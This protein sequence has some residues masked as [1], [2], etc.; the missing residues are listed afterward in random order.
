MR[1]KIAGK[2]VSELLAAPVDRATRRRRSVRLYASS[3]CGYDWGVRPEGL[4]EQALQHL[5]EGYTAMKLRIGTEWAWDGVTVERFVDLMRALSKAVDGRM[6]L[7]LDGNQRL[8]E[9][10]ALTIA[11]VLDE[12]RFT[13]F[14]EPI[15]QTDIEGYARLNAVVE[16]PITGGEQFATVEQFRPYLEQRAYDIVQPDAGICGLTEL[17]QIVELADQLRRGL[18]PAQLAQRA[19]GNGPRPRR[20]RRSAAEPGAL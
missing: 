17:M 18:L 19:D 8:T 2:R 16:M 20:R 11:R 1:G 4:I 14:E 6:E 10:E 3:G 13:W 12:L 15:P 5:D 9:A 7:M